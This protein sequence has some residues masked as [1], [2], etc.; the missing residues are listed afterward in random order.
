MNALV[1]EAVR[2]GVALGYDSSNDDHKIIILSCYAKPNLNDTLVDVFSLRNVTWKRINH[3]P[4][5]L[6]FHYGVFLHGA[7]HWFVYSDASLIAFDLSC[8]KFKPMPM[9]GIS[10][11]IK[12]LD[13]GGCLAMFAQQKRSNYQIDQVD[14]W[15]MKEYGVAESWDENK[16]YYT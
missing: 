1:R 9:P 6:D 11:P 12:L 14:I 16:S 15:M 10:A 2:T 7:I 8:D 5:H 13:F 4:Y 3:F